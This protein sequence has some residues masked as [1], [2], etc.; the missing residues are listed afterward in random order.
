M[1]ACSKLPVA[2]AKRVAP[3]SCAR[4]LRWGLLIEYL[5]DMSNQYLSRL[6]GSESLQKSR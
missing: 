4:Q 5:D 3:E 1:I 2:R 6:V